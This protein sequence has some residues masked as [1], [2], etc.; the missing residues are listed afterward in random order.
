MLSPIQIGA[1]LAL[2]AVSGLLAYR[3]AISLYV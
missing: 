1:I 2:S 3:L